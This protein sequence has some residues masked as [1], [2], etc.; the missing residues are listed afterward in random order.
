MSA[1]PPPL[2]GPDAIQA[3]NPT[4]RAPHR[5]YLLVLAGVYAGLRGTKTVV[6]TVKSA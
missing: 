4:V 5:L 1:S 2:T 3:A 6:E